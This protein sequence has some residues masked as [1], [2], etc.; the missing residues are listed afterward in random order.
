MHKT[1]TYASALEEERWD[2]LALDYCLNLASLLEGPEWSKRILLFNVQFLHRVCNAL[3]FYQ[4]GV[5]TLLLS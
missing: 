2:L 5:I 4:T 3:S 1:K